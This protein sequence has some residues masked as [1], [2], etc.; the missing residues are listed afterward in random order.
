MKSEM[1]DVCLRVY[2]FLSLKMFYLAQDEE[3]RSAALC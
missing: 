3:W 1:T 2:A